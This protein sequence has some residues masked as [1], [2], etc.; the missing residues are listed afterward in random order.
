MMSRPGARRINSTARVLPANPQ[1]PVTRTFMPMRGSRSLHSG[2][3]PSPG[4]RARR[5]QTLLPGPH[6]F[7]HDLGQAL[8]DG[9]LPVMGLHLAEIAVV[10]DVIADPVL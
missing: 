3:G 10:A 4:S 8:R 6:D 1:I 9:P 7:G 5:R 2:R